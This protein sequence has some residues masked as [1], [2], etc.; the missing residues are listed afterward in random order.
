M[1]RS[2]SFSSSCL[3]SQWLPHPSQKFFHSYGAIRDSK[4]LSRALL[5]HHEAAISTILHPLDNGHYE[6]LLAPCTVP[7][8]GILC[9]CYD[10]LISRSQ[11]KVEVGRAQCHFT[12]IHQHLSSTGP[13]K[14]RRF[15]WSPAEGKLV[16]I[17]NIFFHMCCF[18]QKS[19]F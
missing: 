8:E 18:Y 6:I 3:L 12:E 7:R 19:R 13:R 2:Q 10:S 1:S 5:L 15:F 9:A 16:F 11:S 17:F 14:P 4:E